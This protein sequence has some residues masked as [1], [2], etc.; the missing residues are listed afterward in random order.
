MRSDLM[1]K[2]ELFKRLKL[3]DF[4]N[5]EPQS[6]AIHEFR[7]YILIV[8]AITCTIIFL[9]ASFLSKLVPDTGIFVLD[10]V[11]YDYYYCFLIPT[12]IIPTFVIIYLNWLSMR[13]FEH[14]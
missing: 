11:K 10:F 3:R 1:G 6:S 2:A 13:I 7:A 5:N 14:N 9:Y 12:M 4:R 8:F